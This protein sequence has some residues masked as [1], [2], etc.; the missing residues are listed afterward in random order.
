VS[1]PFISVVVPVRNGEAHLRDCLVSLSRLE[2]PGERHEIVVVD[3]GSR[4]RTGAIA[5]ELGIR[6]V[7]EADPGVGNARNAGVAAARGELVAFLDCDCR[8]STGWLGEIAAAFADGGAAAVAGEIV[9][10]PPRGAA[11]RYAARR[12]PFWQEWT[13]LGRGAVHLVGA[14]CA[15]RRGALAEVGGFDPRVRWSSEDID[16]SLRLRRAGFEIRHATRALVFH[17]HRGTVRGLACQHFGYGRGQALIARRYADEFPWG[18]RA[19]ARAWT[20]VGRA[21]LRL[22][23][24]A[25]A[26]E[27]AAEHEALDLVRRVAQRL[28]FARGMLAARAAA[29]RRAGG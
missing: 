6:C 12:K 25:A 13:R 9:S 28:G 1:A 18:A 17:R 20:D 5:R 23:R 24:A 7:H 27:G 16:L 4:D 2:Y 26:R 15:V 21:A 8:A 22:I 10:M 11:E 19:E 29:P 3:N 14:N